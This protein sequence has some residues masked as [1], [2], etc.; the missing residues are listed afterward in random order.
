MS[1]KGQIHK[2]DNHTMVKR[3]RTQQGLW[4]GWRARRDL[5]IRTSSAMRAEA[6]WKETGGAGRDLRS[7]HQQDISSLIQMKR[8][9]RSINCAVSV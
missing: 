7:R 9:T 8:E 4:R 2:L 3:T 5:R 6:E 1:R